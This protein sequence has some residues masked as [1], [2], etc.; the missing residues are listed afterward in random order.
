[1]V[2]CMRFLKDHTFL[3]IFP[4][5]DSLLDDVIEFEMVLQCARERINQPG[6]DTQDSKKRHIEGVQRQPHKLKIAVQQTQA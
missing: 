3:T 5:G 1:M 4:F 2:A 6:T